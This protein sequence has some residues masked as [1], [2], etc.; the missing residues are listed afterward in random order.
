MFGREHVDGAAAHAEGAARKVGLV[1]LVLHADQLGDDVALAHLVVHAQRHHHL[2][3]VLRRADAVDGADAGD[4]E[5][6]AA[7]EQALGGRQAH[8]LDVLVDRAVLL[9]EQVA[10]R[11]VGLG[12]EVVVVADEVLDR[13]LREELAEL[14]V[15]L[16]RQRLVRRKDDRRAAQPRDDVGHGEGLAR[17]GDA[18]QRLPAQAV[19]DAGRQLGNRLGLVAGRRIGLEQLERRARERDE[20]ARHRARR[21]LHLAQ[22]DHR[23]LPSRIAVCAEAQNRTG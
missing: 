14:A 4:D 1:A 12:L 22:L 20:P 21:V 15:Q 6:V 16:R 2:V 7:F 13:V 18:E 3:I 5:H 9:D 23:T 17:A 10:L 11:H 8:L 19:H